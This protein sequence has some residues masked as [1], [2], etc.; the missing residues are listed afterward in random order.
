M[1]KGHKPAIFV[2]STCY[3]LGQ[4]R[5]DLK[6]FIESLGLDPILSDFSSFP[7]NPSYDIVRN[8][9]ETIK[10]RADIFILIIGGRY[11][12]IADN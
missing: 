4:I 3:D 11:G 7:I 1:P 6:Q 2:S 9:R 5:A 12:G 10:N 8:C